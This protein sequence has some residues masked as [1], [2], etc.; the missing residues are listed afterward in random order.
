MK[1]MTDAPTLP[2]RLATAPQ[3]PVQP[4]WV[5]IQGSLAE[6]CKHAWGPFKSPS[7]AYTWVADKGI[8]WD[9]VRLLDYEV[10]NGSGA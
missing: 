6:G 4:Q 7:E 1:S 10:D 9:I 2:T 5:I 3:K 8:Q